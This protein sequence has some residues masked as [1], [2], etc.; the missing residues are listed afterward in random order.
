[1]KFCV[2]KVDLQSEGRLNFLKYGQ[3]N[4]Q[5]CCFFKYKYLIFYTFIKIFE[6]YGLI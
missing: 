1:M 2:L 5:K 4:C 6:L 3:K